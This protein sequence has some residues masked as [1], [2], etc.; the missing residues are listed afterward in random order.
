MKAERKLDIALQSDI[1]LL[2]RGGE[3]IPLNGKSLQAPWLAT[4]LV[5]CFT[6]SD[7]PVQ[8]LTGGCAEKSKKKLTEREQTNMRT[9]GKERNVCESQLPCPRNRGW[10]D[11]KY[12]KEGHVIN[13]EG[14]YSLARGV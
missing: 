6:T 7:V 5:N 10:A 13:R 14:E 12:W 3:A 8:R 4:T 11:S 1:M 2:F 9:D